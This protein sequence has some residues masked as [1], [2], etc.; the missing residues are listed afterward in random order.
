MSKEI[1]KKQTVYNQ[2]AWI[3]NYQPTIKEQHIHMGGKTEQPQEADHSGYTDFE[4]VNDQAQKASTS[5]KRGRPKRT[6]KAIVK[7]FVYKAHKDGR[8][9]ERLQMFFEGLKQL[10]W[11]DADTQ[12]KSFLRIFSGEE[13]SVRV[14]WTGNINTLAELFRELVTR[15]GY[16]KLPEGESIWVMVNAR[17]WDKEGNREFGNGRLAATRPPVED[18]EG[19]AFFVK[20]L[21]PDLSLDEAIEVVKQ[22]QC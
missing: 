19:I 5:G 14:T 8:T 10:G 11:I 2:M 6:G 9:N 15:K 18:L 21:N 17:F 12:Q 20:L 3:L 16:V 7:S 4:E 13:T 1:D 22:S